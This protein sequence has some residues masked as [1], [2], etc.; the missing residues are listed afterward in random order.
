[1]TDRSEEH[2]ERDLA[3]LRRAFEGLSARHR[4]VL[5][6]W[7]VLGESDRAVAA[8]TGVPEAAVG[9]EVDRARVELGVRL[10]ELRHR[11]SMR[12]ADAG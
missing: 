6:R 4:Q 9:R 10:R 3:D 2:G 5:W 8:G 1:M 7:A 12:I 11:R